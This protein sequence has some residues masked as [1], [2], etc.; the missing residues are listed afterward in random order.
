MTFKRDVFGDYR[1]TYRW[2]DAWGGNGNSTVPGW[3]VCEL[4]EYVGGATRVHRDGPQYLHERASPEVYA[5]HAV[6]VAASK[7]LGA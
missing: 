3:C 5:L 4:R 1:S 2:I 6:Y 7:G